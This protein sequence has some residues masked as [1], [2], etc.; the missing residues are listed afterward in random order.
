MNNI[1]TDS[2]GNKFTAK[3][4][5]IKSRELNAT[6]EGGLWTWEVNKDGD[7]YLWFQQF[8]KVGA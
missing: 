6:A 4:A 5:F 3:T 7:F 8:A 2:K 1:Y